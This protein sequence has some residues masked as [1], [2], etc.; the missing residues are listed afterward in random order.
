MKLR[1]SF[2]FSTI[3]EERGRKRLA[4]GKGLLYPETFTRSRQTFGGLCTF[5][6]GVSTMVIPS[7]FLTFTEHLAGFKGPH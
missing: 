4:K 7:V 2:V 6:K 3:S 1:G 5:D